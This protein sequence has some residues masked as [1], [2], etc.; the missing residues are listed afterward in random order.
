MIKLGMV[1]VTKLYQRGED[2][3]LKK[4]FEY[5]IELFT[6]A[7]TLDPNHAQARRAL[8]NALVQKCDELG[9]PSKIKIGLMT[10]KTLGQLALFKKNPQKRIEIAQSHLIQ[11]P[12]NA[13]VRLALGEALSDAGHIDGAIAELEIAVET[14]PRYVPA[15][16]IL[17][18]AYKEK[19]MTQEAENALQRAKQLAPEDRDIDRLLREVSAVATMRKGVEE[20]KSYRDILKDKEKAE[21]LER[22]QRLVKT[23]QDI[24]RDLQQLMKELESNPQEIRII[25]KIADLYFDRKKEYKTARQ[26][27]ERAVKLNTMDSALKNRVD[28]C[29]IKMYEKRIEELTKANDPSCTEVKRQKLQFEIQSYLRRVA[30]QPTDMSLRF[31]LGKRYYNAAVIDKA[32]VE[33]QQS[34]KDPKFKVDSYMYLG[35]SFRRK[36]MYDLAVDQ[37]AKALEGGILLGEKPLFIRYNMALSYADAKEYQKAIQEGK[38]IM[39]IDINYRDILQLVEKWSQEASKP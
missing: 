39:A 10:P 36:G 25:K 37:L 34:V 19:Y 13:K 30:D 9:A 14:Q 3:L 32:I 27:Y 5:A 18:I 2:A 15:Y 21:E 26:W 24:E 6:Q 4:N 8:Y 7:I 35:M 12:F 33:F 17:A 22:R 38:K 29:T 28:D 11:D 16:K 1:D 20:A 31:E 23:D